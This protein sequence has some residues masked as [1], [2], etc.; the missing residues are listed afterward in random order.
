LGQFPYLFWNEFCT[1]AQQMASN[2]HIT[3]EILIE[4]IKNDDENAF[5]ILFDR[6]YRTGLNLIYRYVGDVPT[7]EDLA[8]G[9]FIKIWNKRDILEIKTVFPAY[10]RRACINETLNYLQSKKKFIFTEPDSWDMN[11]ADTEADDRERQ[12][13]QETLEIH[14]RKAIDQLPEKCRIVFLL[15]RFEGLSH[16]EIAD[17]LDISTKTI[18]NH[19]TKA[20]KMLKDAMLQLGVGTLLI[21]FGNFFQNG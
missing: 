20:L 9:V 7:S 19:M 18:E 3:D 11:L 10:F 12:G 21:I 8:Q 14:L 5:R 16:K 4:R 15:N 1:F 17:Q 13:E 2:N 6:Y